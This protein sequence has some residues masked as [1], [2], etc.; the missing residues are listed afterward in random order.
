MRTKAFGSLQAAIVFSIITVGC[1]PSESEVVSARIVGA[2]NTATL[3]KRNSGAM[4]YGS[5]IVSVRLNGA[6][7]DATH[8]PIVLE[9]KGDHAITMKWTDARNLYVS[10]QD[11]STQGINLE[12]VRL[13]D[14]TIRYDD[15]L[16]IR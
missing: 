1:S 6:P 9:L 13:G 2:E 8:G 7:D 4:S 10:C 16:K 12:V 11:C 14:V 5:S 15:N 3:S